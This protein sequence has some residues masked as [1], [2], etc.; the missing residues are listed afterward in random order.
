[1]GL[2][3]Q[4]LNTVVITGASSGLGAALALRYAAPGRILGL[5]GRDLQRLEACAKECR[6]KGATVHLFTGDVCDRAGM[7]AWLGS[8]D[9]AHCIDLVIANA[10]IS[11]GPG[12]MALEDPAQARR[13]FDVNLTGV[14]NTVEPVMG[15]M[16]GRGYGHIA[17]MSSLAGF[18]GFPG[19]PAYCAS[20]AAVRIYGESL[21]QPLKKAGVGVHVICPGFVKSPMTDRNPFFMPF[22][23]NAT[24][25]AEIMEKKIGRGDSRI[26]FPFPMVAGVRVLACLP[27]RVVQIIL[28]N[29]PSKPL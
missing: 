18:R 3:V 6:E 13:V 9:S 16:A 10:G 7:A 15:A 12:P 2:R 5:H 1:M 8:F 17:I 28:K 27:E 23:M 26:A 21:V 25:A 29:S 19:A 24:R 20:K 11:A 4:R 14:L 22:L